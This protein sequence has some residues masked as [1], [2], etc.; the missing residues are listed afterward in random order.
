MV[1]AVP[2]ERGALAEAFVAAGISD[3]RPSSIGAYPAFIAPRLTLLAAGVG[4]AAAAAATATALALAPADLAVSAGVGGGFPGRAEPG[5]LVVATEIIAAD[6]G[7]DSP[8]GFLS[9]TELGFGRNTVPAVDVG[10]SGGDVRTG[11][12]LTVSTA[13]GTDERAR[14][15]AARHDAAAEAMEG[16]G[17]AE[18]ACAT[19]VP[20]AELRGISNSVGRRDRD[21]WDLPA[22]FA[23]LRQAVPRLVELLEER[24]AR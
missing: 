3:L 5:D 16:F 20:V 24:T 12:V 23:A 9:V 13:T 8:A 22:A 2:A 11:A 19:G 4:P 18:A 17:V 1:T 10:L 7:A 21:S 6:L 14:E 15:L